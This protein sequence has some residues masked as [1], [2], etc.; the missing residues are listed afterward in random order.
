[1]FVVVNTG[2]AAINL[3]T[4]PHYL[5]VLWPLAGWGIG[6]SAH[7]WNVFGVFPGDRER[8]VAAEMERLRARRAGASGSR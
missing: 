2:L 7:A 4:T 6:L 5:W 8:A 1:M 3:L